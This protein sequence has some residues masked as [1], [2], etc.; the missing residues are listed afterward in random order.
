[1]TNHYELNFDALAH[2][3]AAGMLVW[4]IIKIA[5]SSTTTEPTRTSPGRTYYLS[6]D[7]QDRLEDGGKVSIDRHHGGD[8]VLTG[9]EVHPDTEAE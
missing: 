6:R 5:E 8:L 3:L 7:E 2:G 9:R 4:A 1:M